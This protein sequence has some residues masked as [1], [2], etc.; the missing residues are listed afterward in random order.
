M[1]PQNIKGQWEDLKGT[2][3]QNLDNLPINYNY[4]LTTDISTIKQKPE[5]S[6]IRSLKYWEN[7]L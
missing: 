7:D 5:H 2:Q 3:M 4:K 6:R 1:R